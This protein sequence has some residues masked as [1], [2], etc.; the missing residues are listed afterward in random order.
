MKRTG[1]FISNGKLTIHWN[2]KTFF[3]LILL[4]FIIG[5]IYGAVLAGTSSEEMLNKLSFLTQGFMD[6]RAE[7]SLVY[8]FL[9]SLGSTA[10]LLLTLFLLG[11]CAIGQPFAGFVPIFR[12]LGLGLSM[13]SFYLQDGIKGVLFCLLLLLPPAAISTFALILG[14]RE[15]IKFSNLFFSVLLPDKNLETKGM[16]KLY[17][18][19]F[20]VL[21]GILLVSALIDCICTFLFA[22]FFGGV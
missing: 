6:Q 1:K 18:T 16:L 11:F 2:Q 9:N 5:M 20:G 21:F 12:G 7:Q 4:L 14:T 10:S 13:G 22:G 8:T 3:Q 17:C 15:S 19:K